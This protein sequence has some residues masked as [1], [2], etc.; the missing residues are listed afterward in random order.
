MTR[1]FQ[2]TSTFLILFL[3]LISNSLYGVT[4]VKVII[5]NAHPT[6]EIKIW[7]VYEYEKG[8]YGYEKCG[9]SKDKGSVLFT[10][11]S[12]DSD[13]MVWSGVIPTKLGYDR[14]FVKVVI[15]LNSETDTIHSISFTEIEQ[16]ETN[17]F[18]RWIFNKP[19]WTASIDYESSSRPT[20][21]VTSPTLQDSILHNME[22]E[23]NE[24]FFKL[25]NLRNDDEMTPRTSRGGST[26]YPILFST[27]IFKNLSEEQL[28]SK[29]K[30]ALISF[31]EDVDFTESL[32]TYKM[33]CCF[34]IDRSGEY[35]EIN[36]Y[37]K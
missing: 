20:E 32:T 26:K 2:L 33:E 13:K 5:P 15:S 12:Y 37:L 4:F 28:R 14:L 34:G 30:T 23:S 35:L 21:S 36:L 11:E 29:V 22:I 18:F 25:T 27:D 17:Y 19:K 10:S 9:T 8:G 6:D 7:S 3:V 31:L 16:N 1:K 24:L